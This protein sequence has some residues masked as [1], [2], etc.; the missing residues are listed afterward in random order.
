MHKDLRGNP[1]YIGQE[2]VYG[3][4]GRYHHFGIHTVLGFTPKMVR[5]SREKDR[6]R[7]SGKAAPGSLVALPYA[8][9]PT[10]VCVLVPLANGGLLGILRGNEPQVGKIALPGGYQMAGE[11]WEEAGC[12]ELREETGFD[13][14]P[15]NVYQC[16][17]LATDE[18][19][20]NMLFAEVEQMEP[21]YNTVPG[22]TGCPEVL[23]V[24]VIKP[25]ALDTLD[26]AFPR[27][28]EAAEAYFKKRHKVGAR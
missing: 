18:Y 22:F 2:V 27:H 19:G 24:V 28:L 26:W 20:N 25:D 10:V 17:T 9:T 21:V 7:E 1:I 5:I 3:A 12:R 6:T 13:V 14:A 8:N 4:G 23:D 16:H 15:E 11:T